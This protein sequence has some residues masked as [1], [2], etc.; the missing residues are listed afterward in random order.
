MGKK[1]ERDAERKAAAIE[2][3][4]VPENT[5]RAFQAATS[6]SAQDIL[7]ALDERIDWTMV[8]EHEL[9][10]VTGNVSIFLAIC[11]RTIPAAPFPLPA[12]D[13]L[14]KTVARKMIGD[15][16]DMSGNFFR[17]FLRVAV[18]AGLEEAVDELLP[19]SDP[20]HRSGPGKLLP[21]EWAKLFGHEDIAQKVKTERA[22][23][24]ARSGRAEL[25]ALNLP[26]VD[27]PKPEEPPKEESGGMTRGRTL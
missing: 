5:R 25:L 3:G 14:A 2:R 18:A 4:R 17:D 21:D 10:G 19:H 15:G 27:D 7:A 1:A 22:A 24:V 23:R 20:D 6:G 26:A 9:N 12:A 13:L 8:F 11:Q 16:I